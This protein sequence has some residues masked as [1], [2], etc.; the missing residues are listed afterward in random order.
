M[1]MTITVEMESIL[2][3]L[4]ETQTM[5]DERIG[6]PRALLRLLHLDLIESWHNV[7]DPDAGPLYGITRLGLSWLQDRDRALIGLRLQD[8]EFVRNSET[9]RAMIHA[10]GRLRSV[11]GEPL[12]LKMEPAHYRNG[13]VCR[14][15]HIMV[16]TPYG[17]QDLRQWEI[18]KSSDAWFTADTGERVAG[19]LNELRKFYKR[20]LT[21]R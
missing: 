20:P 8:Y 21:D 2:R 4:R 18:V 7:D 3:T 16:A 12:Y 10:V 19:H 15:V 14:I 9:W 1:H 13:Q 17:D 5:D 11:H 6:D